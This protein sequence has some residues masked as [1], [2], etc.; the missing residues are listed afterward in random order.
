M[1]AISKKAVSCLAA[2]SLLL[3]LLVIPVQSES[4]LDQATTAYHEKQL[5]DLGILTY[6]VTEEMYTRPVT[7][8]QT[9][10][11]ALSLLGNLTESLS[12]E[13]YAF[14]DI[15]DLPEANKI[16]FAYE[17]GCIAADWRFEPQASCT[18]GEVLRLIVS[19]MG[20]QEV[21]KTFGDGD[22]GYLIMANRLGLLK[23]LSVGQNDA[24][25]WENLIAILHNSLD[26]EILHLLGYNGDGSF[27][28]KVTGVTMLNVYFDIYKVSGVV[29]ANENTSL[30]GDGD[31]GEGYVVVGTQRMKT[32]S[33][34]VG[35][36]LGYYIECYA[37]RKDGI[38]TIVS[39]EK[40][41][42]QNRI[43][44][45]AAEDLLPDNSS[46]S[47]FCL[48]YQ[49][50]RG[51][52]K[53]LHLPSDV[54][55][56]YN[57]K[58]LFD[59]TAEDL[60]I[61][62][63]DITVIDN[64]GDGTPRVVLVHEYKNYVTDSYNEA[65]QTLYS[66]NYDP[67]YLDSSY[68]VSIQSVN[69]DAYLLTDLTE[70]A[71]LSLSISK[72]GKYVHGT[73]VKDKASGQLTQLQEKNGK[74]YFTLDKKTY[75]VSP[76]WDGK[77][78]NGKS[79]RLTLGKRYLIYFDQMGYAAAFIEKNSGLQYGFLYAAS[80][81]HSFGAR[82]RL[83]LF[84]DS[85]TWEEMDLA[86]KVMVDGV[87]YKQSDVAA[88]NV[89]FENGEVKQQM[90]K[91]M[92][93]DDN[94]I[95]K[96]Y[97]PNGMDRT[98]D[99][100]ALSGILNIN[101]TTSYKSNGVFSDYT[102]SLNGAV[103]FILPKVNGVYDDDLFDVIRTS[104]LRNDRNYLFKDFY[105]VSDTM[106]IKVAIMEA[107]LASYDYWNNSAVYVKGIAEVYEEG[108]IKTVLECLN[109]GKD[110]TYYSMED[111]YIET[112][113]PGDILVV[114]LNAVGKIDT[115]VKK[116]YDVTSKTVTESVSVNEK[117]THNAW[118]G[119]IT[120]KDENN[121]LLTQ[122]SGTKRCVP[123]ASAKYITFY[124]LDEKSEDKR[125]RIGTASEISKNA[126]AIV[127]IR[128][129]ECMDVTIME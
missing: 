38:D 53:Q 49:N 111:E 10:G 90:L 64:S 44:T 69:G 125:F 14:S 110:V 81:Q 104:S 57:G 32:G 91:V 106:Q 95:T 84:T 40:S 121:L 4:S 94:E 87:S 71:I 15:A 28:G 43:W 108:E 61:A 96:I 118:Y 16:Q 29:N 72:D 13:S 89:L 24:L 11:A 126:K 20:Y 3:G 45:I 80:V 86:S 65:Q 99:Q 66:K 55:V 22:S 124:D 47:A 88:L 41:L 119:T 56:I 73:V 98:M 101:K 51:D 63:G 127:Y 1:G 79:M 23:G 6:E 36:Y 46:W 58:Q 83:R 102:Y 34:A 48:V 21:A 19:E 115:G 122:E 129:G 7:R 17:Q 75:A 112:V 93:G 27:I 116:I 26:V 128:S 52:I 113:K 107:Q 62:L 100:D 5:M 59:Y 114:H 18:V 76:A 70:Y 77:D 8:A 105:D 35:E 42:I 37:K 33:T 82:I 39:A 97:T 2:V 31:A 60:K 92:V 54:S 9:Y 12:Y 25:T 103:V 78:G 74:T 117:E 120:M 85:G 68:D 123:I 50:E 30:N 109:K 67:L